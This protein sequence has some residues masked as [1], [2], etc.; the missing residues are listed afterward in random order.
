MIV[1]P[2]NL[3]GRTGV[4]AVIPNVRRMGSMFPS[5]SYLF[6]DA[7]AAVQPGDMAIMFSED[8]AKIQPGTKVSAHV[9]TLGEDEKGNMIA[10]MAG[11]DEKIVIKN[12]NGRLHKVIQIVI[13]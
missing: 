5:R 3:E 11:P 2:M 1:S 9:V 6:V 8:F 12:P 7:E 10:Q 4:Y 13:E